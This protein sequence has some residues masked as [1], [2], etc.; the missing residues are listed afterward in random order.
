M[1]GADQVFGAIKAAA[2]VQQ[3]C[4]LRKGSQVVL[5]SG[6]D[7]V[8]AGDLHG[9]LGAFKRI[10]EIANL[11]AHPRRQLVLQWHARVALFVCVDLRGLGAS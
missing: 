9:D 6:G 1:D 11:R 4:C 2:R 7:V 5:A 3:T 10:L 8:V